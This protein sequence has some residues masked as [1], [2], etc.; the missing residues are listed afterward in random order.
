MRC[1]RRHMALPQAL[2]QFHGDE[3]PARCNAVTANGTQKRTCVRRDCRWS[4]FRD[5][6]VREAGGAD[7]LQFCKDF[8][9]AHHLARRPGR[10][11]WQGRQTIRLVT[12]SNKRRRS[13]R[14]EWW[15]DACKCGRWRAPVAAAASRCRLTS[16]LASKA[17]K[18]SRTP[19]K[20]APLL[21]PCALPMQGSSLVLPFPRTVKP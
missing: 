9:A 16:V 5:S 14:L 3:T 11:L 8:R 4:R 10:W 20:C 17:P 7:L 13:P 21:P 15:V 2:W 19:A 18:V 12:R 6:P 1:W